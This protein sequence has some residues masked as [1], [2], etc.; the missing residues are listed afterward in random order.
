MP[1]TFLGFALEV[2]CPRDCARQTATIDHSSPYPTLQWPE[3]FADNFSFF[4]LLGSGSLGIHHAAY[5]S[6]TSLGHSQE[7]VPNLRCSRDPQI[8]F[9]TISPFACLQKHSP[10]CTLHQDTSL[11]LFSELMFSQVTGRTLVASAF[12]P[13]KLRHRSPKSLLKMRE[14]ESTEPTSKLTH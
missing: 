13:V 6:I 7:V 11:Y 8:S 14:E 9:P 12:F 1:R 3:R 4:L 5:G 2:P 10:S